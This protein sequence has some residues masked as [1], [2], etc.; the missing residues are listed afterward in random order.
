MLIER[1]EIEFIVYQFIE[2]LC[3]P[4]AVHSSEISFNEINI[5]SQISN[6]NRAIP[7]FFWSLNW[8]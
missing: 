7:F 3:R 6:R 5:K 1:F 2:H 8:I 4:D